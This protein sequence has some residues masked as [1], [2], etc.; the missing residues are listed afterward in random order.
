MGGLTGEVFTGG[1]LRRGPYGR[2]KTL[3]TEARRVRKRNW[4]LL[5]TKTRARKRVYKRVYKTKP[6]FA[7]FVT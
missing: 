2:T 4:K 3:R 7:L 1:A 5:R 6:S